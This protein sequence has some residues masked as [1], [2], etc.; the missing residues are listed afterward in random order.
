MAFRALNLMRAVR[1]VAAMRMATYTPRV[2]PLIRTAAAAPMMQPV[3]ALSLSAPR[4]GQGLSDRD[5][6]H[7]LEVELSY[8]LADPEAKAVPEFLTIFKEQ[9]KFTIHDEPGKD[10]VQLKR[11][12]GNEDI[13][14]SFSISDINSAEESQRMDADLDSLEKELQDEHPESAARANAEA[15]E[16]ED[17]EG[18]DTFPVEV[19][20][21]VEK[22]G[23]GV[24]T[25]DAL[26][27]S[28][29]MLVSNIIHYNDALAAN[30]DTAEGNW[31][32]R[33]IY[34]GPQFGQLEEDLQ[35]KTRVDTGLAM[36]IPRYIE[37]K[38]QKEYVAW[39]KNV[40]SFVEA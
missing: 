1:P 14:V 33:G 8:E 18:L 23:K 36:F 24:L 5:L 9:S 25:I 15:E 30:E 2:M 39:L 40:R 10:E 11:S 29:E 35:T 7:Q 21:S 12:F 19:Q 4:F 22:A 17:D 27:E 13:T 28:G 37:Y 32:R 26:C 34:V 6:A 38:E 16:L 3:R 20:I 31:K